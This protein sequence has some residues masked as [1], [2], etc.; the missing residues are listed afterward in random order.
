MGEKDGM[1]LVCEHEIPFLVRAFVTSSTAD[2]YNLFGLVAR[3][4]YAVFSD[5]R[6]WEGCPALAN[7]WHMTDWPIFEIGLI[8][9]R[10]IGMLAKPEHRVRAPDPCAKTEMQECYGEDCP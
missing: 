3:S 7:G 5:K 8:Q 10:L 9:Q 2:A 1:L 6:P 4:I